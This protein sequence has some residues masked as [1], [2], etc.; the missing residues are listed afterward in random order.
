MP[1]IGV[2]RTLIRPTAIPLDSPIHIHARLSHFSGGG[3][4]PAG[5]KD[6]AYWNPTCPILCFLTSVIRGE[7]EQPQGST[8]LHPVCMGTVEKVNFSSEDLWQIPSYLL[9]GA[10]PSYWCKA[11]I[12]ANVAG[13]GLCSCTPIHNLMGRVIVIDP[14][15]I[16]M[17]LTYSRHRW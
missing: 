11:S 5:T 4:S 16:I 17:M 7:S 13:V 3:L 9:T 12:P 14:R 6:G 8:V 1:S 15:E 10:R 2:G